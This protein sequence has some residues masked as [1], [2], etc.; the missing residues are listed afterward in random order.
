[1][2]YMDSLTIPEWIKISY[3]HLLLQVKSFFCQTGLLK[4]YLTH[5][6]YPDKYGKMLTINEFN[7]RVYR[8]S[9]TIFEMFL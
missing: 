1:M 6:Y 7:W 9:W 4:T 8:I 3:N 5:F 2:K